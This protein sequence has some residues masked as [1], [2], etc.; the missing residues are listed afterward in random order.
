MWILRSSFRLWEMM[1]GEGISSSC[2]R[3]GADWMLAY[4]SLRIG[5]VRSGTG[6]PENGVVEVG[7][8]NAFK[9][10]LDHYLMGGG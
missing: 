7:S 5:C 2:S 9:R 6:W 4:S 8:V 1:A 3:K 10:K